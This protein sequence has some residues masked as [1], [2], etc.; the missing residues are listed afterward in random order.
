MVRKS[1]AALFILFTFAASFAMA[2]DNPSAETLLK[3]RDETLLALQKENAALLEK[4][5]ALGTKPQLTNEML[6]MKSRRRLQEI[7]ANVKGQRQS[8]VDFET[9]VKWM[10]ANLSGYSRYI[11]AGSFAAGFARVLPIPYAGQASMLT[12]FISQGI[13][14]LNSASVSIA[15]YL[16]T[17]S[18]F[19]S[20]VEALDKTPSPKDAEIAETAR[21]ADTRLLK[22]VNE[23]RSK[24][25]ATSEVSS[26]TLSFLESLNHYVGCTDEYWNKTKSFITR[27]EAY[28]KEKSFLSQSIQG[29]RDRAGAFNSRFQTFEASARKDEPLIKSLITYD[30]LMRD[31][32]VVTA[33]NAG[34]AK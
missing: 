5:N 21:F 34:V 20:R 28:K 11:Q 15:H 18:D 16:A 9:Y 30:E 8:M 33:K 29:L 7:A 13:L 27:S 4:L 17:S 2:A 3:Q 22:D 6:V 19:V 24:L 12:K 10:T 26:S 23:V 25:A 14:S 32:S 31:L 1:V